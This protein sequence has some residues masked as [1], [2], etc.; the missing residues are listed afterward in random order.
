MRKWKHRETSSVSC[1]R[2]PLRASPCWSSWGQF[3]NYCTYYDTSF[4]ASMAF[5]SLN[6][7]EMNEWVN[8]WMKVSKL[9]TWKTRGRGI[10][11]RSG[12]NSGWDVDIMCS[13]HASKIFGASR[14]QMQ[15]WMCWANR[16]TWG[17][18][19]QF[20]QNSHAFSW[21]FTLNWA[22][23]APVFIFLPVVRDRHSLGGSI[24]IFHNPSQTT[25]F[26]GL[27]LWIFP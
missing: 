9:M 10:Y 22:T 16:E 7:C 18:M 20:F 3:W 6:V 12:M 24:L 1:A 11:E 2:H 8:E 25:H 5:S 13:Q 4:L 19:H 21:Q 27:W 23:W 17:H 14:C 26:P 15:P